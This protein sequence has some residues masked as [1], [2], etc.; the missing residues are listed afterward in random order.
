MSITED[1]ADKLAARVVAHI[2][3]TGDEEVV[4][5]LSQILGDSSQTLRD[6]FVTS[7]LVQ[8]T[9]L[10]ADRMLAARMD[11][12]AANEARDRD[13]IRPAGPEGG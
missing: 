10:R 12:F 13:A 8:R 1:L 6:A 4:A 9:A 11:Q 2:E 3:R 7:L 5:L